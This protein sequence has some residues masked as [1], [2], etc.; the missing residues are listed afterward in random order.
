MNQQQVTAHDAEAQDICAHSQAHAFAGL[1]A[2]ADQ[3]HFAPITRRAL[4][5]AVNT[6]ARD[7]GLRASSVM[8]IDALLSC[9]PCRD[10]KTGADRPITPR[11]L[12]T[13]FAANDTLSFRAKGLTD[14]QLRRHFE[15]LEEIGLIRRRDSANGKRFAV[16]KAG[17]IIGA[18]GI[19][20]SPLLARSAELTELADRRREEAEEL[21]GLKAMVRKMRLSCL[22]RDLSGDAIDFL[23]HTA[24]VIRRTST[25]LTE[26]RTILAHLTD[27]LVDHG[28]TVSQQVEVESAPT[29]S[30]KTTA[31]DRQDVRH[32]EP[33]KTYP[34]K[35]TRSDAT[36]S[37]SQLTTLS[38]FY[39][40]QPTTIS[41]AVRIVHDFGQ[42]LGM[43]TELL[44]EA[45][46]RLGWMET[47]QIQD[48][49][50]GRI[51]KISHPEGYLR[52]IL[53]RHTVSAS[54]IPFTS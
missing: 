24:K 43:R 8:V 54:S 14:R 47:L 42:M 35:A 4:M 52:H 12:L 36:I 33:I 45:I 5:A 41:E 3:P 50:A 29:Q 49:I 39:P 34:K 37:W 18:F 44:S 31:T 30:V 2:I 16:K 9:L 13:V 32:K 15:R 25:S 27:L 23:D 7:L 46:G 10:P 26:V 11:C 53:E 6:V 38:D 21:R 19:D 22:G 28:P 17:R 20:L 48:R 40:K 1:G 51:E